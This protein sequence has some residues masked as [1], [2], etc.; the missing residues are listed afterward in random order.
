MLYSIFF[1]TMLVG[2]AGVSF[3]T[4]NTKGKVIGFLLLIINF[5]IFKK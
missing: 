3:L 1:Y 2:F 5:L 4:P